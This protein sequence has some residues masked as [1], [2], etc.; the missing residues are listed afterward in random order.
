MSMIKNLGVIFC[1]LL[2]ISC[3]KQEPAK[4]APGKIPKVNVAKPGI[5]TVERIITAVGTLDAEDQVQVAAEVAGLIQQIKFEEGQEVKQGDILVILDPTNFKL[6]L[7]N[8]K[9]LLER[10]QANLSLA[11]YNYELKKS[12]YEKKFIPEQELQ[13]FSTQLE[14]ARA[15]LTSASA[16]YQIAQKAL[17]NSVIKAPVDKDDKNYTWEVQRKLIS[18]GEYVNP[19]K[20]VVELVNRMTLKLRFTVPEQDAGY[21]TAGKKV[22]FS[23]PAI[24]KNEFEA[25]IFYVSPAATEN[26]RVI[27]VKARFDNIERLLRPGYS[28]NVRFIAQT[29]ENAFTVPR[30]AL[31]FNVDK[32][33]VYV[34][35]DNKLERKDVVVGIQSEDYV[36][37]ISGIIAD[38]DIV[39]R[40]GTF[41]EAGTLVEIISEE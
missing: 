24:S 29:K 22:N 33:Y 28:A 8:T 17:E 2:L 34:V 32:T 37:I 27:T 35:N 6:S 31:R 4:V 39:I 12:L 10:A 18:I 14:R 7:D 3:S 38:D 25:D 19:G 26:T 20:P 16:A 40:S 21:L 23:V 5:E 15:E 36:E 1:L 11:K 9:A 30:R 13:D 41:V